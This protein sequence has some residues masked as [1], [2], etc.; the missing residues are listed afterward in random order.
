MCVGD[1]E[2]ES[3]RACPFCLYGDV[4]FV[5][6]RRTLGWSDPIHR[7]PCTVCVERTDTCMV[8]IERMEE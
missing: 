2:E 8:C 3:G 4:A 6:V 7:G 1:E 5:S